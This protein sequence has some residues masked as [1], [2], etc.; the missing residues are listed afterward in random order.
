MMRCNL[1]SATKLLGLVIA[2]LPVLIHGAK[3]SGSGSRPS[4]GS[5]SSG[6][7]PIY[8]RPSGSSPSG[9]KPSSPSRPTFST[10][11]SPRNPIPSMKPK[12]KTGA[13]TIK[14]GGGG[15]STKALVIAGLAGA[16]VT[17]AAGTFFY[18]GRF[19]SPSCRG[20]YRY[21]SN[22][23][24]RGTSSTGHE[25]PSQIP[26]CPIPEW[27]RQEWYVGELTTLSVLA[28]GSTCA[29]NPDLSV[30]VDT[31]NG[32]GT[33]IPN[34]TLADCMQ[35][36][37][38]DGKCTTGR[39]TFDETNGKCGCCGVG[40]SLTEWDFT[41]GVYTFSTSSPL[42]KFGPPTH[43]IS[44]AILNWPKKRT[45][46]ST[47][48]LISGSTLSGGANFIDQEY[49]CSCGTCNTCGSPRVSYLD[50]AGP[51]AVSDALGR[52]DEQQNTL[53]YDPVDTCIC[54]ANNV[55]CNT[56]PTSSA[57][58]GQ[59]MGFSTVIPIFACV[60]AFRRLLF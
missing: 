31:S 22:F 54:D 47:N 49:M 40:S 46:T 15:Y 3:S 21:S 12:T 30:T 5:G 18:G 44:G 52:S 43:C 1:L 57:A 60:L 25:C 23:C 37:V 58:K 35:K 4:G 55:N 42:E 13:P 36:V 26:L 19:S 56:N 29:I 28:D 24:N 38:S 48:D 51:F 50:W 11:M 20:D 9:S 39:F 41:S 32:N 17:V 45:T 8:S 27:I 2:F 53:A 16:A 6:S 14:S 59:S 34:L 10:V 33:A 7:K